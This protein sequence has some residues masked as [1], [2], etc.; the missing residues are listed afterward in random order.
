MGD[1]PRRLLGPIAALELATVTVLL[2]NL[3]TVHVPAVASAVGPVH[4][5]MYVTVIV[6]ALL[7][8]EQPARSRWLAVLPVVGGVLVLRAFRTA[9]DGRAAVVARR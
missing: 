1:L 4:G 8:P 7:V 3:V 2:V 9:D 6:L 5:L